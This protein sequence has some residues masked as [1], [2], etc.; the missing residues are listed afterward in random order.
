MDFWPS[1]VPGEEPGYEAISGPKFLNFSHFVYP[2]APKMESLGLLSSRSGDKRELSEV[3]SVSL[4][5]ERRVKE[6]GGSVVR[7]EDEE[8]TGIKNF[9]MF[10]KKVHSCT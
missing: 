2:Q 9:K 8:Q 4:V 5:V 6:S 1:L 7:K 10:R 3:M